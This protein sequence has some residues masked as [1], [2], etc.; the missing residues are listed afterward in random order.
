LNSSIVAPC[1]ELVDTWC[2][3]TFQQTLYW[4]R[5]ALMEA[6]SC[7]DLWRSSTYKLCISTLALFAGLSGLVVTRSGWCYTEELVYERW[8]FSIMSFQG[9]KEWLGVIIVNDVMFSYCFFFLYGSSRKKKRLKYFLWSFSVSI[10]WMRRRIIILWNP[11]KQQQ[12]ASSGVLSI[13]W[14]HPIYHYIHCV[15]I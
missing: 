9:F 6:F 12:F 15:I 3:L 10:S 4:F 2:R 13:W 8:I 14:L 7:I 11:F 5:L 1:N